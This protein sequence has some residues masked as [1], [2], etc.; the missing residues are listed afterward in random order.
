MFKTAKHIFIP[1]TVLCL[2]LQS[3][4]KDN[5]VFRDDS[6][7]LSR[8]SGQVISPYVFGFN[9]FEYN[10]DGSFDTHYFYSSTDAHNR[11][12]AKPILKKSYV[13]SGD[14]DFAYAQLLPDKV[15]DNGTPFVD[16]GYWKLIFSNRKLVDKTGRAFNTTG[17]PIQ[18]ENYTYNNKGQ[19][20]TLLKDPDIYGSPAT[21][22]EYSY[23]QRGNLKGFNYYF[24]S[25]LFGAPQKT[26]GNTKKPLFLTKLSS[27]S[28]ASQRT[29]STEADDAWTLIV[30]A[31][32]RCDDKINPFSQQGRILFY[33][34]DRY[35]Y[36]ND[37]ILGIM[38]S[39]PVSVTYKFNPVYYGDYSIEQSFTYLY[40]RKGYPV[41]IREVVSDPSSYTFGDYTKESRIE[42]IRNDD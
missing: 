30:S 29:N 15:T 1:I 18:F 4:N 14:Q 39:N 40:N 10:T 11:N 35:Y 37:Y 12:A 17:D 31:T 3:C 38:K 27:V 41:S 36:F 8:V 19:L 42:Y 6:L 32:I 2:L 25:S 28:N 7:L 21:K 16:N 5:D 23:D 22:V 13:T 34:A 20:I 33:P 26:S 24:P 9:N